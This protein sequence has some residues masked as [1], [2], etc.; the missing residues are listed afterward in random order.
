MC[1]IDGEGPS[2]FWRSNPKA[3]KE[4]KCCECFS[5]IGIG[6]TYELSKGVWDGKFGSF[7]TCEICSKV[8][9]AAHADRRYDEGIS[10]GCLW[11][12]VGVE[13]EGEAI[14]V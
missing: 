10:F 8:R 11:E 1:G 2:A 12:E 7:R 6:E 5:L 3:K 9:S 13:Y 4:H 14:A